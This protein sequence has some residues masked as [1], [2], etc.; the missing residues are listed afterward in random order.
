MVIKKAILNWDL[1][2]TKKRGSVSVRVSFKIL[3]LTLTLTLPL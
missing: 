2:N 1:N 3:K